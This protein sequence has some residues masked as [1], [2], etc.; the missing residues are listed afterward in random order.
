MR[1]DVYPIVSVIILTLIWF[2]P[3][4]SRFVNLSNFFFSSLSPFLSRFQHISFWLVFSLITHSIVFCVPWLQFL[5]WFIWEEI[6]VVSLFFSFFFCLSLFFYCPF[7][8]LSLISL[9]LYLFFFY[10]IFLALFSFFFSSS[11]LY[12]YFSCF[13]FFQPWSYFSLFLYVHIFIGLK[14]T[15]FSI[16]YP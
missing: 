4:F 13:S 3:F 9:F 14:T 16:C 6:S 11:L 5:I 15:P 8:L 2:F 1:M 7:L 10:L 12:L